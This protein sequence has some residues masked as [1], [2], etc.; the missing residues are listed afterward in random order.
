M[1]KGLKSMWCHGRRLGSGDEDVRWNDGKIVDHVI[2]NL[3]QG[4]PA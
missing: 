1:T 3:R 2:A 4:L